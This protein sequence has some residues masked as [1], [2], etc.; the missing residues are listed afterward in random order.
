LKPSY[1]ST[2]LDIKGNNCTEVTQLKIILWNF[3]GTFA[4]VRWYS[5]PS[6]Y[7]TTPSAMKKMTIQ[8]NGKSVLIIGLISGE[9]AVYDW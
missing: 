1:K 5:V 6:S 7:K 2:N 4:I 3:Q 9:R 8:E